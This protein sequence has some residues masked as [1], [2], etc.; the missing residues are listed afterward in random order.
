MINEKNC[1]E[2]LKGKRN[3]GL[4]RRKVTR[5]LRRRYIYAAN[6]AIVP[7]L[8]ERASEWG[9][10]WRVYVRANK[11]LAGAGAGAEWGSSGKRKRSYKRGVIV[12][13]L[14]R[15]RRS[16][17]NVDCRGCKIN[18]LPQFLADTIASATES[19]S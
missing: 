14:G 6:V 10:C 15:S 9:R 8:H 13:K 3:S 2:A 11:W 16:S 5:L 18:K 7:M 1:R 12:P 17:T 4:D 19:N